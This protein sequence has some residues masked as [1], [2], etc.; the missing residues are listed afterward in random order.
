M[1]FHS[2][3]TRNNA[4]AHKH[5]SSQKFIVLLK[6]IVESTNF[7]HALLVFLGELAVLAALPFYPLYVAVLLAAGC[8]AIAYAWDPSFAVLI[9]VL[10]AFPAAVAQ[11]FYSAWF[12]LLLLFL[13]LITF[14]TS[15]HLIAA[16]EFFIFLPLSR[17]PFS[18]LS[19]LI[20]FGMGLASFYFG[21]K[22]VNSIVIPSIFFILLFSA[23]WHVHNAAGF[24]LAY[25]YPI[26]KG[27]LLNKHAVP[28]TKLP[29][30][31]TNAFSNFNP[32]VNGHIISLNE[33]FYYLAGVIFHMFI[34]DATII[35]LLFWTVV[36]TFSAELSGKLQG[37]FSQ[38]ISSLPF[39]FAPVAYY[40]IAM[41][42]HT[43]YPL[44]MLVYPGLAVGLFFCL[45]LLM[46]HVSRENVL[47]REDK[48]K[49]FKWLGV[50]DLSI[51]SQEKGLEDVGNYEDV[52]KQLKRAIVLPLQNPVLVDQYHIKPP[53]GV[54][55][56]G[57]PGCG[58]TM[59]M[60]ALAKEL[61]FTFL[62]VKTSNIL[63]K[64]VGESERNISELFE[65][66]KKVKPCVLFFDE[67]D[68]IGKKRGLSNQDGPKILP[69][70]LQEMDGVN[71]K[72][73]GVIVVGATN[74]PNLLDPALLRPG[75]LDE[76]IY[77]PLPDEHGRR[78][79]FKVLLSPYPKENIDYDLLAAKTPRFSGADIKN[80]IQET[81]RVV[82]E[83]AK[84]KDEVIPITTQ[85]L[86][87]VIEYTKP[88]VRLADV[89]MYEKFKL[90]FERRRGGIQKEEK[91]DKDVVRWEDVVGLDDVKQALLDAIQLPL[92][93]ESLL[94]KYKV[95]P[96]KG[97]LLFGPPGCGK[98]MIAKAA[99]NELKASFI[100][101]SPTDLLSSRATGSER[102]KEIFNRAK[103][104]APAII[105]IDEIETLVPSRKV[106]LSDLVG[107]FLTQLDGVKEMKGVVVLGATNEPEYLD[108][109]LLRP[110]RFDKIFYIPPPDEKG[111]KAILK[112]YLGEFAKHVNLSK[113]AQATEGFSGAD[114][115]SIADTVKM[116]AVKQMVEGKQP[117]I[118]TDTIM[119]II[120]SRKPSITPEM[121]QK[122]QRF[123]Q[124]YG[125]RR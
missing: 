100:Y 70:L 23:V 11:S 78:E 27:F 72:Q 62:Y 34:D 91:D 76:I 71:A 98:T 90:D 14:R 114:L 26:F 17:F 102:I 121:L 45:D 40:V 115:A 68:A 9:G 74:V 56:F 109:A 122:Y 79:I 15:W 41:L 37:R 108:S 87:H 44:E 53:K 113:L 112:E 28:L 67:I 125:E 65:H 54:L 111:R 101:V 60:R 3:Q 118:T 117:H 93:H 5:I 38:T 29:S 8:G 12:S 83:R 58:K 104:N 42:Y 20:I 124:E 95:K 52:K 13:V 18:L 94:E 123:I 106:A 86:L 120:Q 110:G 1:Q 51:V 32:F 75:R 81:A 43:Q 105:F 89:E 31:I 35:Q 107:E 57:P 77:M 116:E 92:L 59:L 73:D 39:L 96:Y 64:W 30:A 46:I 4:Q 63:S 50:Q 36:L 21:S 84:S 99:A 2:T 22:K 85:D 47:M 10:V 82:A 49:Q 33:A 7:F 69:T 16:I 103:E 25:H 48:L 61:K 97:I 80:V 119:K 88:S 55:L 6:H 19:G 24:I 66:A